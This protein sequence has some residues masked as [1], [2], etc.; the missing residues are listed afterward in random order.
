MYEAPFFFG[1]EGRRVWIV[2]DE[3]VSS[4]RDEDGC[5]AF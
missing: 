5:N 3:E 4:N 2:V 1:E